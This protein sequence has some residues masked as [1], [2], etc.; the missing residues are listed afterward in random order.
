KLATQADDTQ[1]G[2]PAFGTTWSVKIRGKHD[3]GPLKMAVVAELERIEITLSHWRP[4]SFTSQFNASETTLTTEQPAEL[5]A[6]V[7]RAQELSQLSGGAYDITVA[8]LVDA[9]GFGPS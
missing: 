4:D 8:P 1:F 9:W 5:V 6:L 7:A 2:G 3:A